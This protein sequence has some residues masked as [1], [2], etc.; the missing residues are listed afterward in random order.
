MPPRHSSLPDIW[1]VTDQR[2]DDALEHVLARLPRGSG[3]IFRHYHL[4]PGARRA[5]FDS[6]ARLA[7]KHA[8][9]VV[10]S[11]TA[12]Q[13]REWGATGAYGP[14]ERLARGPKMFRLVTVHSLREIGAAKRARADA[15]VL[16]PAF[17]TRSHP[18]ATPLGPVRFRLLAARSRGTVIALGGMN[19]ARAR[20]LGARNWAAIDGI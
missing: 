7:R 11:G 18:D 14:P 8:H 3:M 2:N 20:R 4:P 12:G 1:L 19:R 15:I 16:A 13:A 9:T 17:A 10:L 6:L 5:R